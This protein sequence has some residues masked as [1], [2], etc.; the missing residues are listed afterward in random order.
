MLTYV[1]SWVCEMGQQEMHLLHR[2][3][4]THVCSAEPKERLKKATIL[5]VILWCQQAHAHNA[6]ALTHGHHTHTQ[7]KSKNVSVTHLFLR[8]YRLWTLTKAGICPLQNVRDINTGTIGLIDDHLLI[9]ESR[10]S[11][12]FV[13]SS[14]RKA[15]RKDPAE[16]RPL[17]QQDVEGCAVYLTLYSALSLLF[18]LK[19]TQRDLLYGQEPIRS[20][21]NKIWECFSDK[22]GMKKP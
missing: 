16:Y 22:D 6:P 21:A 18:V 8:P 7:N 10:K 13:Q 14:T 17:I 3:P 1:T 5:K 2:P 12:Y 11:R 20:W 4:I 9:E 15:G 19:K